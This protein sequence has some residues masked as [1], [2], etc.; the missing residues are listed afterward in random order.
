MPFLE[1]CRME[2]RVRMLT[3]YD[4]GNWSVLELCRR[5]GVCRDAFYEWRGR[6][7]G[8]ELESFKD[9]S[10]APLHCRHE[11]SAEVAEGVVAGR[12]RYP[13]LGPK[14]LVAVLERKQP[15]GPRPSASTIGEV[16]KK[17]RLISP[18]RR[19][20]PPGDQARPSPAVAPAH[21]AC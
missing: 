10:H 4:T 13:H 20:R 12:R 14:K 16:L 11:T 5:Y 15:E 19:P 3:D 18:G 21:Q 6:R 9:R 8:G 17:A 2:E 1:T 7:D